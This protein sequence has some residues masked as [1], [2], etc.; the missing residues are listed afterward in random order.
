[1]LLVGLGGCGGT[2][3]SSG[4]GEFNAA[5][6]GIV[7]PSSRAGGTLNLVNSGSPDHLDPARTY[8]AWMWDLSRLYARTLVT[9]ASAP[10]ESG[11][12]LVP[13]LATEVPVSPDGGQTWTFR[14]K[15]GVRFE[16][17][18][19]ITSKDL[20][21]GIERTFATDV[22]EGGPAY[23]AEW[24]DNGQ[25]YKGPYKDTSPDKLGLRSVQTP[26]DKTITFK[27]K[28]K[29]SDFPYVLAMP[30]ASPVPRAKDKGSKYDLR[31]VSSGPYKIETYAPDKELVLVRNT[32]WDPA[33]DQVRKALPDR[34]AM[35]LKITQD[36]I[37]NKLVAGSADLDANQGGVGRGAQARI[38]QDPQLKK[39]T[40]AAPSGFLRYLSIQTAVPPFNNIHCRRAVHYAVSKRSL[41]DLHGGNVA[42]GDI[43]ST[44][45][46]NTLPAHKPFDLYPTPEN[47]GDVAKAK[48]EL[49]QCGK[50]DGFRTVLTARTERVKEVGEAESIQ[51]ALKQVG[52]DVEI[53]KLPQGDYFTKTV[54]V[55]NVVRRQGFGL[56]M[57]GWG[58]DYPSPYGFLSELVDGRK[59]KTQGGNTNLA[60]LNDPAVNALIDQALSETDAGRRDELWHQVDRKVM[61]AAVIMPFV[62][63]KTLNY[64]NPRLTNV[65]VHK[66]FGFYD[67]QALGVSE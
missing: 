8:Y 16:D 1:V 18:T 20:K 10:G 32:A 24:L 27:L 45:L 60:E 11:L 56:A 13:D 31:P 4:S 33:T 7:N 35:R 67:F 15:E 23:L 51:Q 38:M 28:G 36:E 62:Y 34:V 14:L 59:I 64:R 26:D 19:P 47:K 9:Y 49:K 42:G 57:S 17:G 22:L 40:D 53:R 44:V 58:S 46:P 43:A 66:A 61:E 12:K 6:S 54:G 39:N 55:P 3:Q 5:A 65:Y 63:E 37:D 41:Q 21:Y 52:I 25:G 50:P 30:F 29:F 2:E 48:D